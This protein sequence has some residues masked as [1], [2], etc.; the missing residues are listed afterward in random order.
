MPR[1]D[2]IYTTVMK[3]LVLYRQNSEYARKVEEFI[4]DYQRWH[5]GSTLEIQDMDT[6]EGMAMAT[7]YDIPSHPAILALR[8]DGGMIQTWHGDNL[9]LMSEVAYYANS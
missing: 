7:L 6:R 8:D 2:I 1:T 3:V 4:H 5:P 9:P